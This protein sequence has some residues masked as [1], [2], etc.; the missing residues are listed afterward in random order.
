M[1]IDLDHAPPD[2]SAKTASAPSPS[3]ALVAVVPTSAR[4]RSVPRWIRR[5]AGPLLL[6]GLWP[7][8]SSL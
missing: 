1:S 2:I 3:P 7:L 6:L 8:A 4:R 5:T